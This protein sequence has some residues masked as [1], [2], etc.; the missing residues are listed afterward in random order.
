MTSAHISLTS[1]HTA[2]VT[3][4]GTE[5]SAI[6]HKEAIARGC[7]LEPSAAKTKTTDEGFDREGAIREAIE[8]MVDAQD[9][10]DW[11]NGGLPDVRA[12]EK[13]VGFK[14]TAAERDSAWAEISEKA[15]SE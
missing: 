13:R 10:G 1:G 12:I 14:V 5:L 9:E 7:S 11:T 8:D 15:D 2:N 3:A 4:E 6:F